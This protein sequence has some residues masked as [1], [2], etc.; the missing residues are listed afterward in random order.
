MQREMMLAAMVTIGGLAG[1]A[2]AALFYLNY[3]ASGVEN[4]TAKFSTVGVETVDSRTSGVDFPDLGTAGSVTATHSAVQINDADQ[5]RG[6]HGNSQYA[7]AF[8]D[9]SYSL[10]FTSAPT[11]LPQGVNYFGRL[12]VGTRRG[13][14]CLVLEARCR[15]RRAQLRRCSGP[16]A[17]QPERLCQPQ[18]RLRP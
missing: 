13:R 15:G 18:R 4:S 10:T 2:R 17:E 5:D 7:V 6:A 14:P 16:A 1:P 8:D 3:E 11:R 12:T 9:T